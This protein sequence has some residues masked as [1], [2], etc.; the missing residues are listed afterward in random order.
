MTNP[1]FVGVDDA[2]RAQLTILLHAGMDKR[3]AAHGTQRPQPV[4]VHDAQVRVNDLVAHHGKDVINVAA[5]AQGKTETFYLAICLLRSDEEKGAGAGPVVVFVPTNALLNNQLKRAKEFGFNAVVYG[6][7]AD[8]TLVTQKDIAYNLSSTNDVDI[9]F[10]TAD[11]MLW[12]IDHLA[13]SP[14]MRVK[15]F[16][17]K[18]R[19]TRRVSWHRVPLVVIDEIHTIAEATENFFTSWLKLWRKLDQFYWYSNARKIGL[20]ATLDDDKGDA[21]NAFL[22][23]ARNWKVVSGGRLRANIALRIVPGRHSNA[24]VNRWI[25]EY[26]EENPS[27]SIIVFVNRKEL[28]RRYVNLL[29]KVSKARRGQGQIELYHASL[30]KATRQAVKN[31]F[32]GAHLGS[33][34]LVVVI[35][36]ELC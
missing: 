20:T 30:N 17:P 29:K 11:M 7:K 32:R 6:N 14:F 34:L 24:T 1:D 13:D 10:V 3:D 15:Q 8:F 16:G 12:S 33:S 36:N 5:T 21:V 28:C 18:Y 4:K 26:I 2:F 19:G 9:I 22:P 25:Q 27:K 23:G 35:I 31:R